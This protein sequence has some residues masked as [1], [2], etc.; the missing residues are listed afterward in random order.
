VFYQT[1]SAST[2]CVPDETTWSMVPFGIAS[3][4]LYASLAWNKTSDLR[5]IA[6][7]DPYNKVLMYAVCPGPGTNC[8][9]AGP[10]ETYAWRC[11]VIDEM[12]PASSVDHQRIAMALGPDGYP[13]IAYQ[14]TSDV[15]PGVLKVARPVAHLGLAGN[16]GP[17]GPFDYTWQCDTI[18]SGG[19]W[20][21]VGDYV[22]IAINSAGLVT[23]AYYESDSYYLS[24]NLKV[25]YQVLPT[26]L[27]LVMRS[28][29]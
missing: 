13:V 14:E 18:D 8:G 21:S 27:P 12:G 17:L 7:F 24:G 2:D 25:A 19:P 20:T 9:S 23:I 4:G 16:C 22:D 15:A 6:H 29:P 5:S 3:G 1:D 28:G 26:F 10:P 11:D